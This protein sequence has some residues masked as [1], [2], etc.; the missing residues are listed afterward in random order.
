MKRKLEI[1]TDQHISFGTD[2]KTFVVGLK[3]KQKEKAKTGRGEGVAARPKLGRDKD[4]TPTSFTDMLPDWMGYGA[5]YII[6]IIPV[7]I[8][9]ATVSV[10]FFS[11]LK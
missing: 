10:L 6:S 9:I 1:L 2:C 4:E 3:G 7:L 5:L 11:S 8:V